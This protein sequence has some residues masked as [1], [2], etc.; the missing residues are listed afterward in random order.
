M[1][2][3]TLYRALDIIE[4]FEGDPDE[5]ELVMEAWQFIYETDAYLELP[6]WYGRH[7]ENLLDAGAL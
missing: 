1:D 5:E 7:I 2:E 4:A 6:A 3:M